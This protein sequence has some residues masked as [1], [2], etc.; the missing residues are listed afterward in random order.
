[1]TE[2]P[3]ELLRTKLSGLPPSSA[4]WIPSVTPA[5]SALLCS[6]L[7]FSQPHIP[8]LGDSGI[9]ENYWELG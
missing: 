2:N 3:S 9:S 1:M 6:P 4:D 8:A 7:G 5:F